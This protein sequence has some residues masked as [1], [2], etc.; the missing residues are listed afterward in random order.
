M[1][2]NGNEYR[3]RDLIKGIDLGDMVVNTPVVPVPTS[4]ESPTADVVLPEAE[5]DSPVAPEKTVPLVSDTQKIEGG[6]KRKN[7]IYLSYE[8]PELEEHF[9]LNMDNLIT[10]LQIL[11]GE[12]DGFGDVYV[13][14]KRSAALPRLS[15]L[16]AHYGRSGN[17]ITIYTDR[18]E[19]R[20]KSFLEQVDQLL[21]D[22]DPNGYS[23]S[24]IDN[25]F[26]LAQE[27]VQAKDPK[28]AKAE[29]E[30]RLVEKIQES[31]NRDVL[32]Q[33]YHLS[34]TETQR[35]LTVFYKGLLSY[36]S[37]LPFE[38]LMLSRHPDADLPML[39]YI[40]L[41]VIVYQVLSATVD[42]RNIAAKDFAKENIDGPAG[43][44]FEFKP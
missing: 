28:K 23:L 6:R 41:P 43:K 5:E 16:N 36:L 14:V 26:Q 24:G 2:E 39:Y 12:G 30:K 8:D 33:L 20:H 13:Q 44:I 40:I 3:Y 25:G 4:K 29:A 10:N 42:A 22:R 34:T 7:A 38:Q 27:L 9:P 37:P 18:L 32:N 21:E 15:N 31:L 19:K 11:K 1:P 17:R 35:F